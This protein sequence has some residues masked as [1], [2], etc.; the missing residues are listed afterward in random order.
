MNFEQE[1]GVCFKN[2]QSVVSFF[3][4]SIIMAI[5]MSFSHLRGNEYEIHH[6]FIGVVSILFSIY[7]YVSVFLNYLNGEESFLP[8]FSKKHL[9]K[10]IEKMPIAIG[11]VFFYS[12]I[13]VILLVTFLLTTIFGLGLINFTH[14]E[15]QGSTSIIF[16]FSIAFLII[17]T[18]LYIYI[19]NVGLIRTLDTQK[20]FEN[21]NP[22]LYIKN[23]IDN[24]AKTCVMI[25]KIMLVGL[26]YFTIFGLT[27]VAG[28]VFVFVTKLFIYQSS[29]IIPLIFVTPIVVWST[30]TQLYIIANY[31]KDTQISDVERE[32]VVTEL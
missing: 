32:Q 19:Y 27:C 23:I 11:F 25:G 17:L 13:F 2:K 22:S 18:L 12:V 20:V 9:A 14:N 10:T 29:S 8:I 24:P 5:I 6:F 15:L 30:F 28:M 7:I 16:L 26:I 4:V 21:L 31:Y 3:I 1:L